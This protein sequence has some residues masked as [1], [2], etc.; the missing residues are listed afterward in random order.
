MLVDAH[1]H[2]TDPRYA[3]VAAIVGGMKDAGLEKIVTVGFDIASSVKCKEIAEKYDDVYF[4]CGVHPSDS[5]GLDDGG[6][7]TLLA[8]TRHPKCVAVGEIGLDYHYPDTDRETQ[9]RALKMQLELVRESGLPV[10]F[11]LRDAYG[12]FDALLKPELHKLQSGAVLHCYSGSKEFAAQYI[13][14]D[15]YFS[16]T[17]SITFKNNRIAA[18]VVPSIP[19]DRILVETD[20]P[21]LTPEPHRGTLNYPA[22]VKYVAEKAAAL[23][24]ETFDA[25]EAYT[26]CNAYRFYGK[27]RRE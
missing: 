19:R 8:L 9:A 3:D 16:F 17:G 2:L 10:V 22:Y 5:A 27:M 15:F 21:Y 11:H 18:E 20:C 24:G 1:A 23:R 25:L 4:T 14:H 12:D 26:T 6:M 13:H 7:Q